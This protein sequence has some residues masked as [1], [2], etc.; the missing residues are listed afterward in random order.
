[1]MKRITEVDIEIRCKERF[2][3]MVCDEPYRFDSA[4]V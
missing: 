3:K 2:G 4:T 1:M